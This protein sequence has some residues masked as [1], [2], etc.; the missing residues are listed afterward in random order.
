MLNLTTTKTRADPHP[1]LE[2]L[3]EICIMAGGLSSRM[4]RNK[5]LLRLKDKSLLRYVTDCAKSCGLPVRIVRRD[6]RPRCGPLGGVYT[7]MKTSTAK[8]ILFLACDMPFITSELLGQMIGASEPVFM[9]NHRTVGFPFLLFRSSLSLVEEQIENGNLSLQRLADALQ[10]RTIVGKRFET[11]NINTPE[12]WTEA[13]RFVATGE[14]LCTH[15][16][17]I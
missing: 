4:G 13:C 8:R 12:D 6:L 5:S 15:D 14:D 16:L 1:C 11:L 17:S 7:A 9:T 10:A 3:C 2:G